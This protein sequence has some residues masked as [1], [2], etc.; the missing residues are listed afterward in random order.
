M[1]HRVAGAALGPRPMQEDM[2]QVFEC[3]RKPGSASVLPDI[4]GQHATC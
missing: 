2:D 4:F 1:R 3:I